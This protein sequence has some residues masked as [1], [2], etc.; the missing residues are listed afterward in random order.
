VLSFARTKI[1]PPQPRRGSVLA[2]P[3]LDAR[4]RHAL[5]NQSLVLLCAPAGFGKTSALAH[6]ITELPAGTALAWVSC[7]TEDSP[8]Q[9]L[10]CMVAALEPFDLPWRS[11]PDALMAGVSRADPPAVRQRALRATTA[12]LIN[13]LDACDVPHGVI[14]AD[15]LQRVE[16]AEV[17]EF[18]AQL[19]E[20][21]TPRWTLVIATRHEPPLPLARLRAR[22]ELAEF[23]AADLQF[24]LDEAKALAERA[25]VAAPLA[26]SLHERTQGW[27]AGFK[28]ALNVVTHAPS[29]RSDSLATLGPAIDRQV[30]D[31]LASEVVDRLPAALRDFLMSCAVLRELTASR[32]AALTGDPQAALRLEQ[33]ESAGLFVDTIDGPELTLRLHD[34]FR[35]ALQQRLT[36]EAPQRLPELYARAAATEPDAAR[37]VNYLLRA[38]RADEAALVLRDHAPALLTQGAVSVVGRLAEQFPPAAAASSALAHV[39]GLLAWARWDFEAMS[40]AMRA[41]EAGYRQAHDDAHADLAL[42]YL[43]VAQNALGRSDQIDARLLALNGEHLGLETRLMVLLARLWNALDQGPHDS[44]GPLLDQMLDLLE[45]TSD[46]ALWYRGY[47]L[48]RLNGLPGTARALDRYVAG[49]LRLTGEAPTPLRALAYAQRALRE[50]WQ[51]RF[52]AARESLA[53]ARADSL[54]LGEPPN[55]RG[56][57]QL[58]GTLVA[59]L[60]GEREAALAQAERM[61]AEHPP[62]RGPWS[63]A[64]HRFYAARTAAAFDERRALDEHL[65]AI[66]RLRDRIPA[67][68]DG[69][70]IPLQAQRAW[71]AGERDHA[72]ASWRRALA[73]EACI[74]RVGSGVE[75]RLRLAAALLEADHDNAARE[76]LVPAAA[77]VAGDAGW[78][79]VLYARQVLPLL[80][81]CAQAGRLGAELGPVVLRWQ[82]VAGGSRPPHEQRAEGSSSQPVPLDAAAP[83]PRE[84]PAHGTASAPKAAA[85][86]AA[87]HLSAREAEVLARMAAGDSNKVIARAFDLSP[88]TVK[89]H[90]ANILDKLGLRSRGQAAAWYHSNVSNVQ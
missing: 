58:A 20:R 62:Q 60:L 78:A 3:A 86:N 90:V 44:A 7:D 69:L 30:F 76:V 61:V 15:D 74:E 25:G 2:R 41:A 89:R 52:D 32:C 55:V 18:L 79:G 6:Q 88:H 50:V 47:P 54:W 19:L 51:G 81:S 59:T 21:F 65:Q 11:E 77:S 35:N 16:H 67:V 31:F 8:L 80:A 72:V 39:R 17:F 42:G 46:Q 27:P 57:L 26:A 70:L 4:L 28:L 14:V 24:T 73:Q 22:G 87:A 84:R 82:S 23:R 10:R 37:R 9:L 75:S 36:R 68:I 66:E 83:A 71:L 43:A 1:Q 13:A 34:L 38:E 64:V 85:A 53:A 33:I 63:Q 49:A 56:T 5:L 40:A 48:P 12:E 29:P 45:G